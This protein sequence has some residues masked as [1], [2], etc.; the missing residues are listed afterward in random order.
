MPRRYKRK[1][2]NRRKR[3]RRFPYSSYKRF[4]RRN[5]RHTGTSMFSKQLINPDNAWT[6]LKWV[7]SS[8]N[9]SAIEGSTTN[10]VLGNG[11]FQPGSPAS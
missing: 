1:F 6:K 10:H 4:G 5:T 9:T 8:Q 7:R 2:R 11:L 3:I